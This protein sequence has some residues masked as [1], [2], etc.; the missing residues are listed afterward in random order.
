MQDLRRL[1]EPVHQVCEAQR[2]GMSAPG[3]SG[4][5]D[6]ALGH[7]LVDDLSS[8]RR[9]ARKL[10]N[11]ARFHPQRGDRSL[12]SYLG[13]CASGMQGLLPLLFPL[14]FYDLDLGSDRAW[15]AQVLG[16]R[17]SSRQALRD[18]YLCAWGRHGDTNFS[19]FLERMGLALPV[20]HRTVAA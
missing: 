19:L 2:L 9:V 16:A 3:W 11:L 17:G 15:A 12:L 1:L 7:A 20:P 6:A 14:A 4:Y 10:V 5:L 13:S 18:A 8:P